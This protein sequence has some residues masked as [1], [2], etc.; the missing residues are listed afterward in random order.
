MAE[1]QRR[2]ICS[3]TGA[4]SSERNGASLDHLR[5]PER[6]QVTPNIGIVAACQEHGI[7]RLWLGQEEMDVRAV[8]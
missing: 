5:V 7:S 8:W 1:G 3:V 2:D 4:R 6:I